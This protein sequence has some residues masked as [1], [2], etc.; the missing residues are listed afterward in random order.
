[1]K[2][3]RDSDA[4][5]EEQRKQ[6]KKIG[7]LHNPQSPLEAGKVSISQWDWDGGSA[8]FFWR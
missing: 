3:A 4:W 1:M 7:A 8:L 6:D 2:V 5:W